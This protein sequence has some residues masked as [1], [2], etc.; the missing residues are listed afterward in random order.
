MTSSTS[1]REYVP[2][3]V[4]PPA[5][6][7]IT[8][9]SIPS[10]LSSSISTSESL[11]SSI[12]S[13]PTSERTF[14]TVIRPLALRMGE[15]DREI[16]PSLFMQYVAS[17]SKPLREASVAADKNLNEWN[18]KSLMRVDVYQALVDAEKHTRE[19]GVKLNDEEEK[20]MKRMVL[21]RKRN[22]L[23]LDEEKRD[24]LFKLK[25][26]IM[27]LEIDFQKNCNEEE[28][29]IL[30]TAEELE[31]VPEDVLSGYEKVTEDGVEKYK[32]TFK[33]PDYTP[34]IKQAINP[35]TR[36]RANQGFES[37]TIQNAPLLS[38]IVRLRHEAAQLLGYESHSA[39]V[40]EVNMNKTPD[41]VL[42]FLEDLKEKLTPLGQA[43]KEKFLALKK[44]EFEERGW[45]WNEERDS[46][47]RLWDYR[48]YDRL[49]LEKELS[50]DENLLQE[51]FPVSHVVPA[52]LDLYKD[53]LGIELVK[54]P[55]EEGE[56]YHED[57]EMFA[58]WENGQVGKENAFKGY[59]T[60]DLFPRN[61]KY[62]HAA[63]W[64]LIPGWTDK[65]GKRQYP[66]VAMVANLA[67]PTPSRPAL[68][69]HQ[70]VVTFLHE[71]GH[72][73]HGLLS[74]TQ[75]SRFHG[76][77]VARDFVEA[78]SQML[79]NWCWEPSVLSALSSH[80]LR[81]S[82]SLP[83]S[84]VSPLLKSRSL[85]QG[86]FNLRQLFFGLYDMKLHTSQWDLSPEGQTKLWNEL[87]QEVSLVEVEEG[88]ELV[89]GQSGFAHIAGGY[90]SGYYGY[91]SSQVYS[92]DMFATKFASDPMN[93]EA[94]MSYR[95]E[96]LK[97]GGSR[98]EMDS[99]VAFLG[100]EPTNKAFLESL[101][102]KKD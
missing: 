7:S 33:T 88:D 26:R 59:I 77:S 71:A 24:E 66:V 63:V 101:L 21:D 102:G 44:Q 92:A 67:K 14:E 35:L 69:K 12:V 79:E 61:N 32:M 62:G 84:L 39:W 64:G 17:G 9:E 2:A 89:G 70:D 20:L 53:L 37:K 47:L 52:V 86:L 4:P 34:V 31:G 97:P 27:G 25:K 83:S 73:F 58:V 74:E 90:S 3:P 8:P 30:F 75:F 95:R 29:F 13:L 40:L 94:G 81:P 18:L 6:T 54:V 45:G 16:E 96:I 78:P 65:D 60:L 41:R 80:Y 11:L 87:R 55:K 1:T 99:L 50:V 82:E 10:T 23:G 5:W 43:E 76:T 38:E 100:R 19:N 91:L 49:S 36:K 28:G 68:M 93:A 57:V 98:D 56:T 51:Y 42:S 48:Y 22:G 72:G 15:M 46:H 85:N